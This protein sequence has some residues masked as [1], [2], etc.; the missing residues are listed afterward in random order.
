MAFQN[1]VARYY[2]KNTKRFLPSQKSREN[3]SIHR[4]LYGPGILSGEQAMRFV[5]KLVSEKIITHA[6]VRV[7]DLG[8]GVGGTIR[9]LQ[10]RYEAEYTGITISR[11]QAE[12]GNMLGTAVEVADFLDSRWFSGQKPYQFIYAIESLQHNPDHKRLM[13]NLQLVTGK[14]SLLMVIDDF[15]R[16]PGTDNRDSHIDPA[17]RIDGLIKRFKKHWHAYGFSYIGDFI[18]V[19]ESAGFILEEQTDLSGYMRNSRVLNRINLAAASILGLHPSPPAWAEN[20]IGGNALKLM[21]EKEAAGYFKLIL[22]R[23]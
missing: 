5:D 11:I 13:Q 20:R 3:G 2:D 15:L 21:Q 19:C 1:K 4:K 6:P 8:C 17:G 18:D 10:K 12:V 22:R 16:G 23:K 14:D 7:L 9:Y